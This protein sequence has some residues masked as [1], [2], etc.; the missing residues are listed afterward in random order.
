ACPGHGDGADAHGELPDQAGEQV[1]DGCRCQGDQQVL[2]DGEAGRCGVGQGAHG[3]TQ[4]IA[5]PRTSEISAL[6]TAPAR[7]SRGASPVRST[8]DAATASPAGPPSRYTATLSPSCDCAALT[9][10]AGAWP[11]MFALDCAIGPISLSS[12]STTGCS[13]MRIITVP[14]VSPRS[15]AR[16]GACGSTMDRP[17]GQ[18]ASIRARACWGTDSTRPSTVDHEPTSTDSGMFLP[19]PL[20]S[21]RAFT[22][23]VSKASHPMPYT[24]SV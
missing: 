21:S 5:V 11:L 17:P 12:S 7:S 23:T 8:M 3:Q 9:V 2:P 16:D 6:D 14:R 1:G 10:L 19:R 24:V 13:G 22:A 18:N 20:A 4:P 15:H